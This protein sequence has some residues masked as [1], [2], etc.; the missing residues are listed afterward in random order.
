[1]AERDSDLDLDYSE[2]EHDGAID[3]CSMWVWTLS[4]PWPASL[5]QNHDVPVDPETPFF[6]T[7]LKPTYNL[8][9]K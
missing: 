6:Q 4:T 9:A 1:M 7:A 5:E 8:E 3:N 2:L